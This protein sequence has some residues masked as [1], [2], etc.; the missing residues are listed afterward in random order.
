M[1]DFVLITGN[2]YKADY[3]AKWLG[4]PVAHQKVD[5]EEIQSLDAR[6]VAEHKARAAFSIVQKPVLVEDSAL[7]FEALGKLPGTLIKWF[8]EE[9]GCDGL[10]KLAQRLPSQRATASIV[11]ALYDG[12][13]EVRFFDA[14]VRG[15]IAPKSRG[16]LAFGWSAIFVPE[17]SAKTYGE[18]TDDELRVSTMRGLAIDKLRAYLTQAEQYFAGGGL[19]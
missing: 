12:D 18:M 1:K 15:S 13:G 2:Q 9:L 7:T 11:Y 6:E 19:G 17:G 14:Q 8:L 5:L 16:D 4:L 10:A 3:L